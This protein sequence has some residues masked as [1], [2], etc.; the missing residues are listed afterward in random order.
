MQPA[1]RVAGEV[2]VSDA[3]HETG[4]PGVNTDLVGMIYPSTP[5]ILNVPASVAN[6]VICHATAW[7][8][9][10]A[11]GICGFGP[12]MRRGRGAVQR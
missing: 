7:R 11:S 6:A 4:D 8:L 1:C 10:A 9:A 3:L 5:L 2:A 12:G